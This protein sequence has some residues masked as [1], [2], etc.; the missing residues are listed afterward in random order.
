MF[1]RSIENNRTSPLTHFSLA[2]ALEAN[3]KAPR[4]RLSVSAFMQDQC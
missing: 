1:R 3:I 2:A 4:G